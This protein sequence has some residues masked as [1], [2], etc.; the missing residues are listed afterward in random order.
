[1]YIIPRAER[2]FTLI[3]LLV[4][5]AIIGLLASLITVF[6]SSAQQKGRDSRRLGDITQIQNA[7]AL[8]SADASGQFPPGTSLA[9]LS[10]GGHI[11]T[12][13]VDPLNSS[14]YVYTYQGLT[15]A[16][17]ACNVGVCP[18]YIIR[19]VFE[20]S[21]NDALGS[22]VDGTVGGVNCNDPAYCVLQ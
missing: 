4:V 22:D 2:G 1:M 16:L 3:E 13:P 6:L 19:A 15:G 20:I 5:I 8:Y 17:T 12:V 21:T 10:A 7:L 9:T 14:S 18:R 11:A